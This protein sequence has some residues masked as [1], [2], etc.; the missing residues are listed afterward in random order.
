MHLNIFRSLLPLRHLW[1]IAIVIFKLLLA[2]PKG[3]FFVVTY[4]PL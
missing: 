2:N 3:V 4:L 1:W